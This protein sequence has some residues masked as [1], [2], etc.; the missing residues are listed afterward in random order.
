MGVD[1]PHEFERELRKERQRLQ[2]AN[3]PDADRDA[4]LTWA[5]RR[6]GSVAVSTL[7][8]YLMRLRRVAGMS[9]TPLVDL[10]RDDYHDLLFALRHDT[11]LSDTTIRNYE[12]TL[13]LWLSDYRGLDWPGDVDRT[14]RDS[15][16]PDPEDMLEQTEIQ[17]LL[18]ACTSQRDIALIEFLADTAARIGLA[19][20]LRV[21]DVELDADRPV[22]RPNPNSLANKDVDIVER[23]L[24]DSRAAIRTF[25]RQAHPRANEPEAALFHKQKAY[26][27]SIEEDD[28]VLNPSALRQHLKRIGERAGIDKPVNPHNFRH[29]AVTRLA[30]EGYTRSE[31]E[32]R[33]GWTVNTDM[34]D[35]YQH[36]TAEQHN[37][38]ILSRAG[39]VDEDDGPDA[40]RHP[41]GNCGE[42]LA[43]HH[44]YCPNCGDAVSRSAREDLDESTDTILTEI[45][46]ATDAQ[47][48]EELR[49]LLDAVEEQPSAHGDTSSEPKSKSS[50][51]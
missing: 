41:C 42:T 4:I 18:S 43:P 40:T 17:R 50:S 8:T 21:Q 15:T 26:G 1:D 12:D 47:T 29:S 38:D 49:T 39:V 25:L 7:G 37:D 44:D 23:P 16:G 11:S 32:H 24:I 31:I 27:D 48:R 51:E 46:E 36:L 20:S 9:S 6:D 13:C 10:D 45:V 19:C 33:T 3:I 5:R 30:R 22:Y 28:G 35:D 14:E 2:D 34:W